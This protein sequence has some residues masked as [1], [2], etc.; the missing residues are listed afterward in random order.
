MRNFLSNL[1]LRYF[2]NILRGFAGREAVAATASS[3]LLLAQPPGRDGRQD[4][5]QAMRSWIRTV[6]WGNEA[7]RWRLIRSDD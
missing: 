4:G 2:A 1:I 7:T 5:A 6:V 3:G